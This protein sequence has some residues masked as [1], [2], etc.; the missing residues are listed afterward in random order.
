[1]SSILTF[2]VFFSHVT[3]LSYTFRAIIIIINLFDNFLTS[4]YFWSGNT[5]NAAKP[6]VFLHF[7]FSGLHFSR[8]Q[9]EAVLFHVFDYGQ[10]SHRASIF[11]HSIQATQREVL[12]QLR[13][14]PPMLWQKCHPV[15][16]CVPDNSLGRL[17]SVA[18]LTLTTSQRQLLLPL[19][20]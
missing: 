7:S 9:C 4:S 16:E 14:T 18:R 13:T 20:Q 11:A 3:A 2:I 8:L 12:T 15:I 5:R 10:C 6:P 17:H 1:M 19:I